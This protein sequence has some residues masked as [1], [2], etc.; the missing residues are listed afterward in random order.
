MKIKDHKKIL[1]RLKEGLLVTFH[2]E[3]PNLARRSLN[4]RQCRIFEWVTNPTADYP[5]DIAVGLQFTDDQRKTY[6]TLYEF[7]FRRNIPH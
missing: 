4:G 5:H 2:S 6:A 3:E 1:S 7:C